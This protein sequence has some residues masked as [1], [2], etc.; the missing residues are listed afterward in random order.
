MS[1]NNWE[2]IDFNKV[3]GGAMKRYISAFYRHQSERFKEY[4]DAVNN[5]KTIVVNDQEVKAKINTKKLFPYEII[6]KY[7]YNGCGCIVTQVRPE[8]EA[9]WK[10]L[11]DWIQTRH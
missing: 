3:P 6:E 4:I 8:Y 2:Q 10:G 9:M 5:N 7:T 1:A 11:N